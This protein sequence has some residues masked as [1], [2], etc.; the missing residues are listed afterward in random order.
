MFLEDWATKKTEEIPD[1]ETAYPH[2]DV[3][4]QMI[5]MCGTEDP[6][7]WPMLDK[8]GK[9]ARDRFQETNGFGDRRMYVNYAQGDEGLEVIYGARKLDRLKALK[10]KWDPEQ[11]FGWHNPIPI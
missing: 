3:R 4:C 8:W 10:K 6:S 7:L 5:I 1:D 9:E 11:I 2:R